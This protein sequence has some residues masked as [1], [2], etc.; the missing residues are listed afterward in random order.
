VFQKRRGGGLKKKG[1]PYCMQVTKWFGGRKR[2]SMSGE[3][4]PSLQWKGGVGRGCKKG[5]SKGVLE[6]LFG[7]AL[8][9]ILKDYE[10][11]DWF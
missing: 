7:E 2:I 1:G 3:L 4:S 5:K 11:R 9:F 6:P 10:P 8:V